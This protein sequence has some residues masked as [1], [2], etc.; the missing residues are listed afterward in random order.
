M[1]LNPWPFIRDTIITSFIKNYLGDF[2]K[3]QK[4]YVVLISV[5][6]G[7]LQ[8]A[9]GIITSPE[10]ISIINMVIS[11]FADVAPIKLDPH[12]VAEV[13]TA[14]LA[15][16][17]IINKFLKASKGLPQVPT[18]VIEKKEITEALKEGGS[19]QIAQVVLKKDPK[20]IT[21]ANAK[22]IV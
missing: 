1:T 18:I 9:V 3:R 15:I 8:V 21:N 5:I 2:I 13:G 7:L 14:I 19:S 22:I 11:I 20:I 4:G 16:W 10:A 6:L 17:G 12:E